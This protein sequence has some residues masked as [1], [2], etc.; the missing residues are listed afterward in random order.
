[1]INTINV[2]KTAK[3]AA[4]KNS[5]K[6]LYL[7]LRAPH[8]TRRALCMHRV[9][10]DLVITKMNEATFALNVFGTRIVLEQQPTNHVVEDVCADDFIVPTIVPFLGKYWCLRT[11]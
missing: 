11:R 1:M 9:R 7:Q 10:D 2:I 5:F 8:T 6:P 3:L 4:K